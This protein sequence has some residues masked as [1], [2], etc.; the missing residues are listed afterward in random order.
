MEIIL[1]TNGKDGTLLHLFRISEKTESVRKE[2]QGHGPFIVDTQTLFNVVIKT[3]PSPRSRLC[4]HSHLVE[5]SFR[6]FHR[7]VSDV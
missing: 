4:L 2:L 7:Q 5:N 6:A 1:L 3:V